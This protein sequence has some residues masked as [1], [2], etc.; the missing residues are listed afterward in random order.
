MQNKLSP[1]CPTLLV[2]LLFWIF[3]TSST[4]M[5]E[6]ST[7]V[8]NGGSLLDSDL[9][10]TLETIKR[11]VQASLKSSAPCVCTVASEQCQLLETLNEAQDNYCHAMVQKV[12]RPLLSLLAE[13]SQLRFVWTDETLTDRKGKRSFDAIAQPK[14]KQILIDTERFAKVSEAARVQLISHELLHMVVIEGSNMSDDGP[15]GPFSGDDGGRQL[16]DTLGAVYASLAIDQGILSRK[17]S[18]LSHPAR[19]FYLFG[20]GGSGQIETA[21]ARSLLLGREET[22]NVFGG[23]WFV[24]PGSRWGLGLTHRQQRINE[25]SVFTRSFQR[26]SWDVSAIYRLRPLD[27]ESE[28][29]SRLQ[30]Q[31]QGGVSHSWIRY[32][33]KDS[34]QELVSETKAIGILA[35]SRILL[36]LTYNFWVYMSSAAELAPFRLKEFE[37]ASKTWHTQT[38][39]GAAYAFSF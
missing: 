35:E 24:E 31:F 26:S 37:I 22:V 3:G 34:Y 19:S 15:H 10:R 38:I 7:F 2:L 36:P 5:A 9:R 11:A 16:L 14:D 32:S 13:K 23:Q 39:F 25:T 33:M 20:G 30:W 8:G 4:Q 21:L 28:F 6:A 29:W 17:V 18:S 27:V 1:R 12:G